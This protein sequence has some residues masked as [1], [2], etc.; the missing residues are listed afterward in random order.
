MLPGHAGECGDAD[1]AY[2]QSELGFK[3]QL[4]LVATETWVMLPI[5]MWPPWFYQIEQPITPLRV[6][7]YGHPDSGG[8]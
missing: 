2:T 5:E 3:N 8:W 7:L 1:Q 6:A 4:G